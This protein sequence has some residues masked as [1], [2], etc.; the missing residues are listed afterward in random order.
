MVTPGVWRG[1]N[2]IAV[3]AAGQKLL[4]PHTLADHIAPH[5]SVW[6]ND[7]RHPSVTKPQSELTVVVHIDVNAVNARTPSDS[8]NC[9]VFP[10]KFTFG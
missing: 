1:I 4:P 7:R 2:Q 3:S 10:R 5:M 6:L 9:A 8:A